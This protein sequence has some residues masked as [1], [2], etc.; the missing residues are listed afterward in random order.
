MWPVTS[1]NYGPDTRVSFTINPVDYLNQV[2]TCG[3]ETDWEEAMKVALGTSRFMR[4]SPAV[5]RRR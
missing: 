3:V 2:P 5:C 4:A 1:E